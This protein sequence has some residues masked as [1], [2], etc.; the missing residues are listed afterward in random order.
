MNFE[1][2]EFDAQTKAFLDEL[3]RSKRLPHALIIESPDTNNAEKLAVF[4]SMYAVCGGEEKPCGVCKNCV[5]AKSG[6]HPDGTY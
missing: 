2:F 3:D 1:G 5:N 6:S 4:L